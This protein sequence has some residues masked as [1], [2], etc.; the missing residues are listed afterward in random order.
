[1]N[2][3]L[4][5]VI[6]LLCCGVFSGVALAE[7]LPRKENAGSAEAAEQ[8]LDLNQ[9][10]LEQLESLPGIGEKKAQAIL[11][12]REQ[13]KGFRSVSQLLQIKGIGRAM[14]RKLKPLLTVGESP[15]PEDRVR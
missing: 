13:H 9:A 6:S 15:T 4:W 1:M 12:F 2:A 3:A 11:A 5:L 8:L 7:D 10:T 14:L